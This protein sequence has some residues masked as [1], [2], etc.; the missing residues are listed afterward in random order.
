MCIPLLWMKPAISARQNK[1]L[2]VL[3]SRRGEKEV[4]VGFFN[5]K[6]NDAESLYTLAKEAIQSLNLDLKNIVG[7]CFDGASNMSGVH[8]G[9]ATLMKEI[10]PFSIYVHCYAHRLNLALGDSL[11]SVANMKNAF[12]TIQSL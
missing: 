5:T 8:G 11:S 2:S 1:Y 6:R 3:R 10:S 7:E 4:F 12:G 9:L